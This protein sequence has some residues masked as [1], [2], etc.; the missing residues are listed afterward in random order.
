MNRCERILISGSLAAA[1]LLSFLGCTRKTPFVDSTTTASK[2]SQTELFTHDDSSPSGSGFSF[3]SSG[4]PNTSVSTP[5]SPSSQTS[6]SNSGVN[7]DTVKIS[8]ISFDTVFVDLV[9]GEERTVC[10]IIEPANATEKVLYTSSDTG[11]MVCEG[12]KLHAVKKGNAT[13]EVCSKSGECSA[14]IPVTVRGKN[15]IPNGFRYGKDGLPAYTPVLEEGVTYVDFNPKNVKH[16]FT[17][18]LVAYEDSEDVFYNE[19]LTVT[20][21]RRMLEQLYANGYILID[22]DYMY[23]YSY[24]TAGTL[25]AKI[26]DSIKVPKGKKPIILSIDNV[27]YPRWDHGKG[28]SDRLQVVDGKLV[29]YTKFADGSELYSDDNETFTILWNFVQE[30]PDFSLSGAM[31]VVAPSGGEGLFGWGTRPG[32]AD[33][34]ESVKQAEEIVRWFNEHGFAFACH[35]YS[36]KSFQDMTVEDIRK[37]IQKWNDE[38]YPIVGRTHVFIYPYGMF[39]QKNSDQAYALS[40]EGFAVFCATSMLGTN[41][42]DFPIKGNAYNERIILSSEMLVRYK[43]KEPLTLLFDPYTV[44]DNDAHSKKLYREE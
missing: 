34:T 37:D 2:T 13:L 16:L 43:D 20:E 35:S 29:T 18:C 5:A 23:E 39:T 10:P 1:I 22:I 31:C 14:K 30:H 7:D 15:D 9:I 36:H 32:S 24:D 27:A 11:V 25:N 6:P 38:V 26:K 42:N 4:F 21:F 17:H 12:G 28:R 19:C 44:Y 8:R 3:P 40:K 41:W 33:Y